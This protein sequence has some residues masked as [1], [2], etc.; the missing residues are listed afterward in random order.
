LPLGGHLDFFPSDVFGSSSS[1]CHAK[2]KSL[3][4]EVHGLPEPIVTD[5]P[6]DAK[7]GHPRALFRKRAWIRLFF[8]TNGIHPGDTVMIERLGDYHYRVA[9]ANNPHSP[10]HSGKGPE[11]IRAIDLFSGPG[12]LTLGLKEAG[13]EPLCCVEMRREA[14]ETY[15]KHTPDAEHHCEDIRQVDFSRYRRAVTL[16]FGGPPCQPFSTGGLRKGAADSRDMIPAFLSVVATVQPEALLMENVPGLAVSSR[17]EYLNWV[18]GCV[19]KLGYIP[20]WRILNAAHYGVPE[21]RRR[22]F[23]VGLRGRQFWFPKP[24][25]GPGT[26]RPLVPS[27]AII[28]FEPIGEPPACP[29]VYAKYPDLRP[30]PYAGQL[31]NGGGRPIDLNKPCH[32]ILASAGGYKTHWVDTQRI[33]PKY[34]LHLMSGGKPW[35]GAVPGARRLTVEESALIQTFPKW[36]TFAG[37]R[38]AQYTQVGDAVPPMLAEQLGLSLVR[39]LKGDAPNESSHFPPN[40]APQL[41]WEE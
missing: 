27:S 1:A 18:L 32:T 3:C 12:G 38:S 15:R 21:N 5:I 10:K 41:L 17:I 8:K 23:I 19:R 13:V 40:A 9:C 25:H 22:L 37:S 30:S 16:V 39:Q 36:L 6:T 7:S 29:V 33:A 31:Y 26:N 11:P 35:E 24:T 20:V 34:H 4:L 28:G 2:S 14:V